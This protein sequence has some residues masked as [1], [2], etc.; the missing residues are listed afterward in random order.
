MLNPQQAM[1]NDAWTHAAPMTSPTTY[2]D[3]WQ[4]DLPLVRPQKQQRLEDD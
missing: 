3:A 1:D 4:E 2:I